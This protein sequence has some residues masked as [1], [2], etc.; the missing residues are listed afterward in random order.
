M[1]MEKIKV[2]FIEETRKNLLIYSSWVEEENPVTL[3]NIMKFIPTTSMITNYHEYEE[4]DTYVM[5]I[6]CFFKYID[7]LNRNLENVLTRFNFD[8]KDKNNRKMYKEISKYLKV[9]F[10]MLANEYTDSIFKD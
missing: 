10:I 1:D 3:G 9:T 4:E 8:T 5:R 7:V 2:A 6:N